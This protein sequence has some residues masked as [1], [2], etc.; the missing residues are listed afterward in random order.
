MADLCA[1]ENFVAVAFDFC[2]PELNFGSIDKIYIGTVGFPM[3]DW[4]DLAEWNLRLDNTTLAD[5]T[6]IRYIHVKGSK[7]LPEK[8]EV[9]ISLKRKSYTD[10]KQT[11]SIAIDE[12][13]DV[14][15]ALVQWL[16]ANPGK[17]FAFWYSSGKHLFGGDNGITAVLDLG[18]EIPEST[19]ELVKYLGTIKWDGVSPER[20]VNPLA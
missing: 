6:K 9:A 8:T 14:N 7:A 13:G 16:E 17:Q 5:D 12:T 1:G 19:D 4:T 10:P 11:V 20:I 15:Y 3:G 2:A 18:D